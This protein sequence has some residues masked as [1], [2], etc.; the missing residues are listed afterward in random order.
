MLTPT[1]FELIWWLAML[2]W[3]AVLVLL[4]P[5]ILNLVQERSDNYIDDLSAWTRNYERLQRRH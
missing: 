2:I 3:V 4:G 5:S 1:D